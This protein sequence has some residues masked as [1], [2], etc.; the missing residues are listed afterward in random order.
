[1]RCDDARERL[2][3]SRYQSGEPDPALA[4]HLR[5][6]AACQAFATEADA[7][8]A[9]LAEEQDRPPRPG[10]DTRFFARLEEQRQSS[11]RAGFTRRLRWGL[12]G[13]LSAGA[14]AAALFFSLQPGPA[15]TMEQELELAMNLE[16]AREL[17]LLQQLEEVEAFEVLSQ[18]EPEEL[19]RLLDEGGEER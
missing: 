15:V 8:D 5:Q 6:C 1:M 16:L 14:A 11:A 3:E 19:E 2:T 4:A 10:F 12:A 9:L 18:V 17:P 7:L 13:L